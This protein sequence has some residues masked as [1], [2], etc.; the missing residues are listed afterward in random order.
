MN[1]FNNTEFVWTVPTT[2]AGTGS[3]NN[4]ATVVA[5]DTVGKLP[6]DIPYNSSTTVPTPYAQIPYNIFDCCGSSNVRVFRNQSYD[7]FINRTGSEVYNSAPIISTCCSICYT[8]CWCFGNPA[9]GCCGCVIPGEVGTCGSTFAC[10]CNP[11]QVGTT[12][13]Y[14]QR[15]RFTRYNYTP[16]QWN[17]ETIVSKNYTY[18]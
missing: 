2:P 5:T 18:S 9:F 4:Y 3:W 1:F 6:A 15:D 8:G 7:V 17:V 14:L 10:N 11:C 12:Y 16:H 13:Y